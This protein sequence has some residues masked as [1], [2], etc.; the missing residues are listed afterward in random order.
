V[1][2]YAGY[3]QVIDATQ[4]GLA[5][6]ARDVF[7]PYREGKAPRLIGFGLV[8]V[9]V[10]VT[11]FAIILTATG[12]GFAHWY[13]DMTIAQANHQPPPALPDGF[14]TTLLLAAAASI[15]IMGFHSIGIGQI[16]LGNRNV[17]GAAG[18]GIVGALKNLL[19][20]LMLAV[21]GIV[22][23]LGVSIGVGILVVLLALIGKL[24]GLWL[25]FVLVVPVYIALLLFAVTTMLGVMYH[26]WRDVCGDDDATGAA[27]AMAA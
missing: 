24:V 22:V 18:D 14:W 26:F 8:M 2:L 27:G 16:A 4:H 10:Y 20:L 7:R 11:I 25:M 15:F 17:F 23:W 13:L 5:A 12:G 9:T 6:R 1:P 3:L 21:G 19:P